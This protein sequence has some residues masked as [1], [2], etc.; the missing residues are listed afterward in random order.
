MP[1]DPD[2]LVRAAANGAGAY[3]TWATRL[4]TSTRTWD[5]VSCTD[6]D[7]PRDDRVGRLAGPVHDP[8]AGR[9]R[10]PAT[11]RKLEIVEAHEAPTVGEPE[12]LV[13]EVFRCE[14]ATGTMPTAD[15]LDED[16]RV[17]VGRVDGRPVTT[18]T[19]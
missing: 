18:A 8:R 19:T 2:V 9:R 17:W 6:R 4:G 7:Y 1:T 5:D 10:P 3:R 14:G 15:C 16:F 11:S 13:D 12:A